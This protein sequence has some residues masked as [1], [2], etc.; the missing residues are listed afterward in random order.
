VVSVELDPPK[1]GSLER[2]LGTA[3]ELEEQMK[4]LGYM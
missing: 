4:L 1:G 2:L 3:A